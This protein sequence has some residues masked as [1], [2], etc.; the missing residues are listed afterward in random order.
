[1]AFNY[2]ISFVSCS[3]RQFCFS[4]PWQLIFF[5][6]HFVESKS[7]HVAKASL[8]LVIYDLSL[9]SA[10]IVSGCHHAQLT[11]TLEGSQRF[12]QGAAQLRFFCCFL[13]TRL[14]AAGLG[15]DYPKAEG[16]SSRHIS[17]FLRWAVYCS[18]CQTMHNS[19]S[20]PPQKMGR[21]GPQGKPSISHIY[22]EPEKYEIRSPH[23]L[24]G[25]T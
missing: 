13:T 10:R 15:G 14:E 5:I 18:N 16:P 11:L 1:M 9:P 12:L 8:E 19:L 17:R 4:W 20:F 22:K 23:T 6:F 7:H 24:R 21:D 25:T 3:W 2:C